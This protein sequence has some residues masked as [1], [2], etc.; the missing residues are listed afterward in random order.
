MS[1]RG[2][3]RLGSDNKGSRWRFHSGDQVSL[4]EEA[5]VDDKKARVVGEASVKH[6]ARGG[7]S[8]GPEG[9]RMRREQ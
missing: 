4:R 8:P 2:E 3:G 9:A 5:P 1:G 7:V 6:D